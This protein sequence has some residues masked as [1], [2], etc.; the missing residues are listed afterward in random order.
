LIWVCTPNNPTGGVVTR[1]DF[2]RF[3]DAVPENVLVV[4]DEAYYEFAAGP[5]Q[6]NTIDEYVGS[7]PNVAVLRTFSKLYGLA[8][9]RVG[10][11]AGPEEIVTAVGKG[12]HYY[13]VS[14]LS[15]VAALASLDGD[16]E[17]ARRRQINAEHRAALGS[18][19]SEL[20][21]DWHRSEANFIAIDVGDADAV[22]ARLLD[23]GVATRSLAALGAPELLR[24]TVGTEAQNVRLFELLAS[25]NAAA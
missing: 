12:R 16:D 6:L 20:G 1:Q 15:C 17:V 24:V 13:D 23:G 10:Y 3:I 25:S 2:R 11:L 21:L 14:S 4:V 5:D 18:G 22:A 9:L 7:R 8:G 19:L